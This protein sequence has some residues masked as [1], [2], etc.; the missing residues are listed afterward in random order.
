MQVPQLLVGKAV[1]LLLFLLLFN[2]FTKEDAAVSF[3]ILIQCCFN[4]DNFC[5]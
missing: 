5:F 2:L 1:L 3:E 4:K